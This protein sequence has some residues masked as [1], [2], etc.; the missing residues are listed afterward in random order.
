MKYFI[1]YTFVN[2]D[3]NVGIDIDGKITS[4]QQI[5]DIE[6]LINE[7]YIDTDNKAIGKAVISNYILLSGDES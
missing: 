2:G 7:N 5:R 4:M 1:Y 6:N 3:G